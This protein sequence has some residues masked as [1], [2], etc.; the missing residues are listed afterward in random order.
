[1][2]YFYRTPMKMYICHWAFILL[3]KGDV[4]LALWQGSFASRA[5]TDAGCG[6]ADAGCVPAF[7]AC[8]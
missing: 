8:E 3:G 4:L 2:K 7:A 6:A 5:W 1:M